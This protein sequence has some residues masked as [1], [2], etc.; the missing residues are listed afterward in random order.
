MRERA[1]GETQTKKM[2]A[3][4]KILLSDIFIKHL[5]HRHGYLSD[6]SRYYVLLRAG[7]KVVLRPPASSTAIRVFL[8]GLINLLGQLFTSGEG[9]EG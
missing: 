6:D 2:N 8:D 3:A 7:E 5:P 9:Y 4:A 1:A